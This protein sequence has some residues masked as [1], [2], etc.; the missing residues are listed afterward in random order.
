MSVSCNRPHRTH[1]APVR[2]T[3]LKIYMEEVLDKITAIIKR[4]FSFLN[5]WYQF[6]NYKIRCLMY[7][8]S[9]ILF[10]P[11]TMCIKGKVANVFD[12]LNISHLYPS[13]QLL[14]QSLQ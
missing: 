7:F 10:P 6:Y 14:V 3:V 8:L 1:Y 12:S 4:I 13:W 5:L 9:K 2:K 11:H